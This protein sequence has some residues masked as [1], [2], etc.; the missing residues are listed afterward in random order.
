MHG[1]VWEWVADKYASSYP[2]E[3]VADPVGPE[4]GMPVI[5]GGSWENAA[6][7]HRSANRE[8][9]QNSGQK[10]EALGFRLAYTKE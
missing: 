9:M 10:S 8:Y 4:S 1:N 3:A 5:R 6:A 7:K 2:A